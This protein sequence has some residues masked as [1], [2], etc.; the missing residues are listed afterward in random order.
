MAYWVS[1]RDATS[2]EPGRM[3]SDAAT[4]EAAQEQ[5]RKQGLLPETVEPADLASDPSLSRPR[6]QSS[7]GQMRIGIGVGLLISCVWSAALTEVYRW[8]GK[9]DFATVVVVVLYLVV[10]AWLIWSGNKELGRGR[11][12]A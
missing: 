6:R 10:P 2:G 12:Q 4:A 9:G 7:L 11:D 1:G 5:A 8:V 3:L